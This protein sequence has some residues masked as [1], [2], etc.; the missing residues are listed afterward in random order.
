MRDRTFDRMGPLF[1]VV[2]REETEPTQTQI[3]DHLRNLMPKQRRTRKSLGDGRVAVPHTV[4]RFDEEFPNIENVPGPR[5]E[6]N[7]KGF[8]AG[9]R[10]ARYRAAGI[11]ILRCDGKPMW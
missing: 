10:S 1:Q 2:R 9:Q 6:K 5:T 4:V 7:P 8:P 11:R 3:G